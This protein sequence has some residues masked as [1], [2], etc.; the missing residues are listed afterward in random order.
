MAFILDCSS[1]KS[2]FESISNIFGCSSEQITQVLLSLDLEKT[3]KENWKDIDIPAPQYLYEYVVDKLGNHEKLTEVVWFHGTRTLKEN[4]LT[5]GIFPLNDSLS[6]VWDSLIS[7]APSETVQDNLKELQTN[8]VGDHLYNLRT[9]DEIHWGPYGI[10]VRDVAFNTDKLHQH[11]YLGM[12]ELVEDI[13][14]GYRKKFDTCLTEYYTEKLV[15]VLVT[16]KSTTSLHNGCIETALG[17]LYKIVR[18]ETIDGL[19]VRC[20]DKKGSAIIGKEIID[21]EYL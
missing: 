13:L 3:Y 2:A 7:S 21:I 18:E 17:Y 10:L 12:P 14:N 9:N 5:K 1:Q 8:G 16:F 20:I 19:S 4:D 6:I 15:P 11:D